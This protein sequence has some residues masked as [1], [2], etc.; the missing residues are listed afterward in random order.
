MDLHSVETFQP[1]VPSG[2]LKGFNKPRPPAVAVDIARIERARPKTRCGFDATIELELSW[3]SP[4]GPGWDAV[5][6]YVRAVGP[7]PELSFDDT[8]YMATLVDGRPMLTVWTRDWPPGGLLDFDLEI[9][10]VDRLLRRGPSTRV[11]VHA[12]AKPVQRYEAELHSMAGAVEH[13]ARMPPGD[14]M[15]WDMVV[16]PAVL[17][18]MASGTVKLDACSAWSPYGC[19]DVETVVLASETLTIPAKAGGTRPTKTACIGVRQAS[20]RV[21]RLVF[22]DYGDT[23]YIGAAEWVEDG[24]EDWPRVAH[25]CPALLS[26]AVAEGNLEPPPTSE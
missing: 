14:S 13:Q 8:P 7:A 2:Y 20:G 26:G 23:S 16:T 21:A 6:L 10:A 9:F 24:G 19:G 15:R 25:G 3:A 12:D 4:E 18:R 17:A 22:F 5:G 11:H 1:N